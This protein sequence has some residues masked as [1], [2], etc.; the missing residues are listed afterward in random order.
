MDNRVV[1]NLREFD[2]LTR[3]E[4]RQLQEQL[5]RRLISNTRHHPLVADR[6]ETFDE[7][8]DSAHF[9]K[10]FHDIPVELTGDNRSMLHRRAAL[11][12]R[13]PGE[14]GGSMVLSSG[15]TTGRPKL[16]WLTFDEMLRGARFHGK[17]YA[18]GGIRADDCVLTFGLPGPLSADSTVLA[19]L[20]VTGCVVIPAGSVEYTDDLIEMAKDLG[21]TALLVMSSDLVQLLQRLE[22]RDERLP[23]I[24]LVLGGGEVFP[25]SVRAYARRLLGNGDLVVRSIFQTNEAGPIGYQCEHTADDV[26][27]IQEELVYVEARDNGVGAGTL[28]AT[29]MDRYLSPAVRIEVGDII[30]L[31]DDGCPCGRTSR[32]MRVLG[33]EERIMKVG[34]ERFRASLLV[35]M[36]SG[37]GIG[38]HQASILVTRDQAGRDQVALALDESVASPSMKTTIRERLVLA[39]PQLARQ[40]EAGVVGP[41]GFAPL[42]EQDLVRSPYGKKVWLVDR[43]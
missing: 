36:L 15:G 25:A 12:G 33:R 29:N 19:G 39:Y 8:V 24:R 31:V 6:L 16:S 27:H 11:G 42:R 28:I 22:E 4:Q 23:G 18:T 37:L 34:G 26:F 14:T 30:E 17:G 41:F 3:D 32:M 7:N 21:V 2:Y 9:W 13:L 43:R 35:E 5:L 20:S 38:P 10:A 1:R 40:V